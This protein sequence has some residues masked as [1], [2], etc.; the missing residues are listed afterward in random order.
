MKQIPI[1]PRFKHNRHSIAFCSKV[2]YKKRSIVTIG[3]SSEKRPE[4][5]VKCDHMAKEV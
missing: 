5:G 2:Q 4:F 1:L 3:S